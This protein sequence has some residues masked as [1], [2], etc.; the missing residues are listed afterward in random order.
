MKLLRALEAGQI[1]RVGDTVTLPVDVRVIAATNRDL[2]AMV[3]A[4]EFREDL[5]Y[6]LAVVPL[7][8]PPLRD[9]RDDIPLLVGH[10]VAKLSG[11]GPVPLVDEAAMRALVRYR[12][13]GNVRELQN[14][15]ER[16]MVLHPGGPLQ[17]A[18]LPERVR[19]AQPAN[20][21][22]LG[23]LPDEGVD[24]EQLEKELIRRAL[25]KCGG[26]QSRTARYL[27]ITRNTLLYR[28]EKFGLKGAGAGDEEAST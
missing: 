11:D 28:L 4:G 12:W 1:D 22:V 15:L 23:E 8:L 2:E 6:R 9:R 20:A 16:A 19:A 26:N 7:H 25:D 13:P 24:L 27:G 18:D 3:K 17:E 10:F 21:G 5:Y 14:V